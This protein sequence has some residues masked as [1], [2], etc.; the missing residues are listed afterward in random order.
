MAELKKEG[1]IRYIG[2][3]EYDVEDLRQASKVAHIDVLQ[4]EVC[5]KRS[6]KRHADFSSVLGMDPACSDQ[7]DSRRMQRAWHCCRS[8]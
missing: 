3:C 6:N 8:V 7:W 4:I 2:V 5:H 1:K